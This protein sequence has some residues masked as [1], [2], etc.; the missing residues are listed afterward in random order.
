MKNYLVQGINV[1]STSN[2]T[3]LLN[4]PLHEETNKYLS[5]TTLFIKDLIAVTC[6]GLY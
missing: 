5:Y 6:F 4:V 1:Q 3:S 2:C